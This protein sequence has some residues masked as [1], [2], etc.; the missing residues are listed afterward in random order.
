MKQTQINN[1]FS[2]LIALSFACEQKAKESKWGNESKERNE[3]E[4]GD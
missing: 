1:R 2:I 3:I 4:W